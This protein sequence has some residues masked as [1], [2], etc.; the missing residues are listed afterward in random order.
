[1]PYTLPYLGRIMRK[2]S[3]YLTDAQAERLATLARLEG[4]SQAEVLR[5]A[6]ESYAPRT[7]SDRDFA[8][9]GSGT[10]PGG[11]IADVDEHEL[12]AGFGE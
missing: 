5:D 2:T 8:L 9:F 1:M 3:V 7:S 12:M 6:I 11:S 4:R 10:G